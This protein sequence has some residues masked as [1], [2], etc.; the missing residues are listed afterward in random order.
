MPTITG[1][2][3]VTMKDEEKAKLMEEI[4]V[5]VEDAFGFPPM[6]KC[7]MLIHVPK[8]NACEAA[9]DQSTIIVWTA[10]GKTVAQRRKMHHNI[11][12]AFVKALGYRG[13]M[14][15]ITIIKDH[16]PINVGIDGVL[17]SD[18]N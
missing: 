12:E 3:T 1:F 4:G 15:I 9:Q 16:D 6:S 2:T 10:P 13:P 17:R 7:F 18:L 5:A 8:E 14:K 11:N